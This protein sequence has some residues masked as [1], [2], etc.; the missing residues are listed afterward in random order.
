MFH[1]ISY[2]IFRQE[3][4][5]KMLNYKAYKLEATKLIYLRGL[6]NIYNKTY[7]RIIKYNNRKDF[8]RIL[9]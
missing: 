1:C 8:K 3:S 7:K 9:K 2:S 4:Y 6:I 5:N